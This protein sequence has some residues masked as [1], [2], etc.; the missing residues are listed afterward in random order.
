MLTRKMYVSLLVCLFAA[1]AA[2][3]LEVL[4][5]RYSASVYTSFSFAGDGANEMVFDSSGNLY[6]LT[7]YNE[8]ALYKITPDG[9]TTTFATGLDNPQDVVFGGGKAYGNKLYVANHDSNNIICVDLSGNKLVFKTMTEQ[10]HCVGIDLGSSYGGLMYSGT[11]SPFSLYKIPKTED[12]QF[13]ADLNKLNF[14]I[15]FDPGTRFDGKM[16]LAMTTEEPDWI[17]SILKIEPDGSQ[18][19]FLDNFF[20]G[21][22]DFDTTPGANFGGDLY[23]CSSRVRRISPDGTYTDILMRTTGMGLSGA[24]TFGSDGAMYLLELDTTNDMAYVWQVTPEPMTLS[25]LAV[26]SLALLKRRRI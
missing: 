14:D 3:A 7:N 15:A 18:T 16:Y 1:P 17:G 23:S 9:T 4:D 25:L 24:L 8:G 19:V 20:T 5:S 2:F 10:P 22:I 6:I 26:G 13:L 21:R 12:V 11:D